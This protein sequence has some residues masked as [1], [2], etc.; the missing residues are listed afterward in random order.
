MKA[1][2][3]RVAT[4]KVG[5]TEERIIEFNDHNGSGGVIRIQPSNSGLT[6]RFTSLDSGVQI[7]IG[8]EK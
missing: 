4:I 1:P 6:V 5:K 7:I 2:K 8:D 3:L